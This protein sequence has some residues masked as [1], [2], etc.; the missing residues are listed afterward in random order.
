M[1]P[2][3][4]L[5]HLSGDGPAYLAHWLRRQAVPME[6]R[7]ADAGDAFA[8][9]IDAY[10]ALAVLGGEMSANDELPSLRQAEA[11]ILQAMAAGR[12]VLGHCLGGQLMARALGSRI[13]DSP[14]PEI[15]WQTIGIEPGEAARAW[16]GEGD[17]ATVFQWHYEAFE[18]PPGA[19]R[20]ARSAAC[21]N[22]A[23]SIGPHLGLQFHVE[24]D[25]EKVDRWSR[26]DG[27]RWRR[28]LRT[29]PR[30]VQHGTAMRNGIALHLQAHQALADRLYARWLEAAP[31]S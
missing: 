15:G 6:L 28:A 25:R 18:L 13:V 10:S 4:V 24:V 19:E 9:S 1:K 8:Q 14:L 31:R 17:V 29:S 21:G 12:P 3:L 23:F 30:T 20:L 22:Q 7:I 27:Q 11:L 26:E 16:F 2:V 5:Q